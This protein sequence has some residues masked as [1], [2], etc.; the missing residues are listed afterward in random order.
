[1]Q[2]RDFREIADSYLSDELLIETN[3]EVISHLEDC[4][5]CRRE[6]SARREVRGTLR[7]AFANAPE[8]Q[9][10]AEF[11]EQLKSQLKANALYSG[12][13]SLTGPLGWWS[14][15]KPR[16]TLWLALAACLVFAGGFGL[17]VLRQKLA[18]GHSAH[19]Q[20]AG[21]HPAPNRSPQL[22][23][24]L[25]VDV[26]KMELAKSAVGDHRDC[27]IQFRLAE[28]TIDL[29]EA[30][31][32]YDAAYINLQKAVSSQVE[33]LPAQL[34]VVEAHSCVFASRRFA[35][36]VLR[37]HGRIVSLLVTNLDSSNEAKATS[38]RSLSGSPHQAIA[39]SQIEGYQVSCFETARHAVF[40]VSD[41]PEGEN[42]AV[43]EG[44]APAVIAHLARTEIAI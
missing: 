35:H 33:G 34:E 43:A 37:Y 40:V 1:M 8:R 12:R 42:L 5:E 6:M 24:R 23:P 4:A 39:Y 29:D 21:S 41:L 44:L 7:A 28:K 13:A 16:R 11:G 22:G 36:L 18:T 31:R 15:G 10:R 30:G 20:V 14:S 3:H 38:S 19:D 25:A 27:A 26:A 9:I 32:K 17:F 2:C